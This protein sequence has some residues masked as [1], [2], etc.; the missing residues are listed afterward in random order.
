M[1]DVDTVCYVALFRSGRAESR[2]AALFLAARQHL[3]LIQTYTAAQSAEPS[4]G[5]RAEPSIGWRTLHT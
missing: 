4:I 3:T 5:W 2:G 1:L